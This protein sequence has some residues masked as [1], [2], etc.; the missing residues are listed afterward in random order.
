MEFQLTKK[1]YKYPNGREASDKYIE[2][3]V[4]NERVGEILSTFNLMGLEENKINLDKLSGGKIEYFEWWGSDLHFITSNPENTS[5]YFD[6]Y[7]NQF[8]MKEYITVPTTKIK[9]LLDAYIL[10]LNAD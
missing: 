1:D 2:T 10:F 8:N 7:L 6:I 9:E 5:L 3:K 4:P